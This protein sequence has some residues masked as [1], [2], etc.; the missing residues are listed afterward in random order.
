MAP[1]PPFRPLL[2]GLL[3]GILPGLFACTGGLAP[4]PTARYSPL[5]YVELATDND[6]RLRVHG[7]GSGSLTHRQYPR[8]HLHYPAATFTYAPLLRTRDTL[9]A[10]EAFTVAF[11]RM[12]VAVDDAGSERSCRM[13]RRAWLVSR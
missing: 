12:Q 9:A 13:L 8:H 4:A 6:W 10:T 2:C 5:D 1:L 7:D 3:F 11:T